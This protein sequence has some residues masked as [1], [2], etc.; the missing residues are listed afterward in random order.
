MSLLSWN[1]DNTEPQTGLSM[2]VLCIHHDSILQG[3]LRTG[4]ASQTIFQ[5]N[6]H[7]FVEEL[8]LQTRKHCLTYLVKYFKCRR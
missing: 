1:K 3:K 6:T 8:L 5:E 2:Q 7:T 4:R